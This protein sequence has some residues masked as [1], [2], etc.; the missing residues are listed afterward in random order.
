MGKALIENSIF[1]NAIA[2]EANPDPGGET[3][4]PLSSFI[5]TASKLRSGKGERCSVH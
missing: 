5:S 1:G 3:G 4:T 2:L